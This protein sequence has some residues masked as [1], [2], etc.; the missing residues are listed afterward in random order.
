MTYHN[1]MNTLSIRKLRM[2]KARDFNSLEIPFVL[3]SR[4]E[5]IY[6]FTYEG[7]S[8]AQ[9]DF[10]IATRLDIKKNRK[11]LDDL[12]KVNDCVKLFKRA[13]GIKIREIFIK[14]P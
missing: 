8:D 12:L 6:E 11:A 3:T 9:I 13:N 7:S 14:R 1:H 10:S 4:D 2:T 5:P